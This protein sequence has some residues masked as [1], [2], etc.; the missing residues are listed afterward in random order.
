MP[1]VAGAFSEVG[2]SVLEGVER[3]SGRP[4]FSQDEEELIKAARHALKSHRSQKMS[5]LEKGALADRVLH[6]G[7]G[8][9]TFA[10]KLG[11]LLRKDSR[12]LP[13]VEVEYHNLCIEA[14]ALV[15]KAGNP[16]VLNSALSLLRT[17]TF[18]RPP[19]AP[20][21]ILD[22]VSGVLKPGRMTL[23]LG[24]PSGGKSVLLQ[25]LSGRLRPS[26]NLRI[27]GSIKYNGLGLDDFQS[28]R[29]AG[30]V[31]Q[32]DNHIADLTVQETVEFA[33]RCQA[34]PQQREMLYARLDAASRRNIGSRRVLAAEDARLGAAEGG[35]TQELQLPS[36]HAPAST[37]S[38]SGR[39]SP[40]G[41]GP[42]Q[43]GLGSGSGRG[44]RQASEELLDAEEE[45]AEA[46]RQVV[47]HRLLPYLVLRIMGLA[48]TAQTLVGSTEQRGISGGERKRLTT[49]EILVGQQ[50]VVFMDEISTGLDSATA[51]SV[52]KT[53]RDVCHSLDRTFLI[54]LLQP[55]PEVIQLFDD[56][57]LLTDGRVIYHGPVGDVLAHFQM[58]LRLMCPTRKDPGSFLQEVTTPAG[59][60]LYADA[61]LL[62][63]GGLTEADR[64]PA[65]LLAAPPTKLL[66]SLEQM[67]RAF[68]EQTAYGQGILHQLEHAPFEPTPQS[69]RAVQ[70]APY[71]NSAW[72]LVREV[73][74]RQL[75]LNLRMKH[76]YIARVVQT[77]VMGLIISSLFATIQPTPEDGRSVVAVCVVSAIFL[78]M[79][80]AP[81]L[82]FAFLSK[83]VFYKQRDNHLF[84][85]WKFSLAQVITQMPQSTM[86]AIVFSLVVYWI[87]GLTRTASNFFIYLL[88]TW[89]SSNCLAGLFRMVG[90]AGSTMVM[91][92]SVAML[93][94]LLMV[95]TNGFSI[96]RPAIPGYMIWLYWLNPLSWSIR[97]IVINELTAPRWQYEVAPG[98][99]AGQTIMEPFG[100]PPDHA[101]IWGAVG[102]LWGML[103]VYTIGATIALRLTNPPAPQPTVPE[104][105]KRKETSRNIF[106]RLQRQ[107]R[108]RRQL[109]ATLSPTKSRLRRM[110][111]GLQ[112]P[113]AASAGDVEAPPSHPAE[114]KPAAGVEMVAAAASDGQAALTNGHG[115]A[116]AVAGSSAAADGAGKAAPLAPVQLTNGSS[117]AQDKVAV[118]FTPVTIV[119]RDLRYYVPDPSHGEAAGVVK[120]AGDKDIA[121]KL[122]LLKGVS[123]YA[124]PGDLTA[125]MGGSG[126][127]KTTLMDCV[128]GRKTVGLLRGDILV[129]GYPKVQATWSRV[130]G[131]VE[132]Q[133]IHSGRCTVRESLVF[134][135][136]LRLAA[137]IADDKVA[138]LVEEVLEMTELARL[139][140]SI[141]G[142]GDG[143]HGLSVEQRK[144][145]SIAVEMVAAP[146][147]MFLDEPT[148][149]L[150]ARAAAIV[151][152]A[153]QNVAKSNRTVVVTIHQPSTE[154]FESF[155]MLLL[156]QLGGR[157]S[158]FGPLGLESRELIAYLERQPGVHSVRPGSNPATWM[159]EVTGGSMATIYEAAD[160]D[161][162]AVYAGS[163]L[164]Q[165]NDATAERLV[166]EGL[167]AHQPLAVASQYAASYGVQR[168]MLLKKFMMVYY[169]SPQY[170]FVRL[171]MTA[172]IALIYGITYRNQGYIQAPANIGSVQNVMGL[173]FSAAIFMGMFNAMSVQPLVAAERVVLYRE[174]A[175]MLY[176]P[177]PYSL[178]LG[179]AEVPY[180]LLQ[181][182]VMVNMVYWL[183]H[184]SH[185]A[186]KYFYFLLLYSITLLMYTLCGQFLVAATP[187]QLMAQLL[188]ASLNQLWTIS[189]G[190]LIPYPMI[191]KGWKWLNRI[192]PTTWILYGLG[193]SQL[194][195]SDVPMVAF[196]TQ[197]TTV[198]EFMTSYFDYDF[199][200]IWWCTLIV[201]SFAVFFR[202]SFS[203]LLR[204]VSYQR[205]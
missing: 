80:S 46:M 84:P 172:I 143:G 139:Q 154:I 32:Q 173:L 59:Q 123:F 48:H 96:V 132:Q 166:E 65:A 134:S 205:R 117:K 55:A 4:R 17:V 197:H 163:E 184:F 112:D 193:G 191:P 5:R 160:V 186:W 185:T 111:P 38:S 180:L 194:G 40:S 113:S 90:Y 13:T 159:L 115:A 49:A 103:V 33:F 167:A 15:G 138:Q 10:Q 28:R 108:T 35:G 2:Q 102:F 202:L 200:F 145:L 94:L 131:Y 188:A 110:L 121:G 47:G 25:A 195:D 7:H 74:R 99:T 63:A 34:G 146:A 177:G 174:R 71:G 37:H 153:I 183:V 109:L 114:A 127:G 70:T 86:E 42:V 116:R 136:R 85:V 44:S 61:E 62:K 162:P 41:L 1:G 135:A 124:V 53:F 11:T 157:L 179:L 142:E 9:L 178:A 182:L 196:G 52:I 95:V 23:L 151:M 128:L 168:K 91:A 45:F 125:L 147:V 24:P 170:N 122:E 150:D 175:A 181:V 87:S 12:P 149:G 129:N 144:R 21:T 98:M 39:P 22:G 29:T 169:R 126:A 69:R 130:C 141:V 165:Q 133:D 27:S 198:G 56:I 31:Q 119:C 89:S 156:M 204:Y 101:Y 67:Q 66:V 51:Y 152:R 78:S 88:I 54:S 20:H 79:S 76:F 19:T 58:R 161:F 93:I 187:N 77:L 16:S 6:S 148:S 3:R 104:A 199:S 64:A 73:V 26:R 106:S 176:S 57:L 100:F 201:F 72:V 189:N 68:W 36:G 75:R 120:D 43:E 164:R 50:P 158:C 192:S 137:D 155:D 190:F 97:A 8:E 118:P 171:A 82:A 92:N 83:S 203:L 81:Q 107:L 30:L 60:W 18:Q 14:D 105:E 140:H